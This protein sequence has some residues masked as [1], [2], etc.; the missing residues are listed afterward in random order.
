MCMCNATDSVIIRFTSIKGQPYNLSQVLLS[1]SSKLATKNQEMDLFKAALTNSKKK[2]A[3]KYTF[4]HKIGFGSYSNIWKA[5][6]NNTGAVV[7]VKE[8]HKH[9]TSQMKFK[10]ELRCGKLLKGCPYI[11]TP[12][13]SF[14]IE[15]AYCLVQEIAYGGDLCSRIIDLGM[16]KEATSKSYFYQICKALQYM[17]RRKLVHLDIKPDNFILKDVAGTTLVLID[18]G[19]TNR[20]GKKLEKPCGTVPYMAPEAFDGNGVPLDG[21]T[22]GPSLDMWALGVLLFCML[23]GASPWKKAVLSDPHF[24]EFYRWEMGISS[25]PP[26]GW[27]KFTPFLCQF[28]KTLLSVDNTCRCNIQQA[29]CSLDEEWL[30]AAGLS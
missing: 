24:C 7:A 12:H 19:L 26:R 15:S 23:T 13:N 28:L 5:L 14:E 17:H 21:L 27:E 11:C 25:L 1:T 20:N 6:D 30:V 22:A 29:L 4:I 18:F 16:L 3:E 8:I 9:R 2:G 10:K